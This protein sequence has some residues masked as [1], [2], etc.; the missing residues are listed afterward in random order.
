MSHT[1][2]SPTDKQPDT[3]QNAIA[4]HLNEHELHAFSRAPESEDFQALRRHLGICNSCRNKLQT[5]QEAEALLTQNLDIICSDTRQSP[6]KTQL[7]ELTHS[8][9]MEELDSLDT[10]SVPSNK[11]H[12]LSW[13]QSIKKLF[14]HRMPVLAIPTTAFASFVFAFLILSTDNSV[15]KGIIGFQDSDA[16]VLTQQQQ[17]TPGL[18]FFHQPEK[19]ERIVPEYG[20]FNVKVDNSRHFIDI[21]WPAIE[22]AESYTVELLEISNSVSQHVSQVS[23][24]DTTWK[25]NRN[26]IRPGQLYRLKLTGTTTDKYT[27]RHTGGFVLR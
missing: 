7:H 11:Q 20:G 24:E 8:F 10:L 12:T 6:L 14:E 13:F 26:S 16:L 4:Q 2:Q 3:A 17:P 27:F 1:A 19:E 15:D 18:G 22:N 5:L 21:H 23:T 25:I 9:A